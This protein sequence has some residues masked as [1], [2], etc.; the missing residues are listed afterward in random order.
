MIPILYPASETEF[1]TNGLGML[2]DAI[3]ATVEEQV[4]V[5]YELEMERLVPPR[6]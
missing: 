5:I 1:A 6:P 3:D 2:S 4:N